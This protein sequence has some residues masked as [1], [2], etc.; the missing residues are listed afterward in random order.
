MIP[1]HLLKILEGQ[2]SSF[3]SKS[4]KSIEVA[5][6]RTFLSDLKIGDVIEGILLKN[7][8]TLS[9][10]ETPTGE[11]FTAKGQIRAQEGELVRLKVIGSGSPLEVKVVE[12]DETTPLLKDSLSLLATS[13]TN[14]IRLNSNLKLVRGLQKYL[15]KGVYKD[16][17]L[18]N[19]AILKEVIDTLDI[20]ENT[21]SKDLQEKALFFSKPFF[22]K[23]DTLL[24]R[25][26]GEKE[27]LFEKGISSNEKGPATKEADPKNILQKN[28][29]NPSP[30]RPEPSSKRGFSKVEVSISENAIKSKDIQVSKITE[31]N[32]MVNKD[33][34]TKNKDI[35]NNNSTITWLKKED[36]TAFKKAKR[37]PTDSTIN[38]QNE[39]DLSKDEGVSLRKVI[40]QNLKGFQDKNRIEKPF[41]QRENLQNGHIEKEKNIPDVLK[42]P[43]LKNDNDSFNEPFSN[44]KGPFERV[45]IEKGV[46]P[47]KKVQ[48]DQEIAPKTSEDTQ[49]KEVIKST[50]EPNLEA[51]QKTSLEGR[52]VERA[53]KTEQFLLNRSSQKSVQERD[54]SKEGLNIQHLEKDPEEIAKNI[55]KGLINLTETNDRIHAHLLKL[56]LEVFAFPIL[57]K[58]G[59]GIGQWMYW[60]EKDTKRGEDENEF[61]HIAFDLD[62]TNLGELFIHL[63]VEPDGLSINVQ[64]EEKSLCIIRENLPVL[65][66][67]IRALGLKIKN[68]DLSSRKDSIET[69]LPVSSNGSFHLVT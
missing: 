54:I 14:L 13:K 33:I 9:Q 64:S 47:N 44:R 65:Y 38:K 26:K 57:F 55:F 61:Y 16:E 45:L 40:R 28:D 5:S 52:P 19:I 8:G 18:P 24:E 58:E 22:E 11:I 42:S 36:L 46:N 31:E 10:I 34:T 32:Y 35:E 21:S 25:S 53:S 17:I 15:K 41:I 7:E 49:S 4:S 30:S 37:S 63:I 50:K 67:K 69:L 59:L 66:E 3:F 48:L 51:F 1:P 20:D 68:I 62:L 2:I 60:Q 23:L 12:K 43:L 29:Y 39:K 6:K 27:K 56:G